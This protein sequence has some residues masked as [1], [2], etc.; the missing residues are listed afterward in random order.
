MNE[1]D[2]SLLTAYLDDELTAGQ[3]REVEAELSRRPELNAILDEL[4]FVRGLV[5]NLPRPTMTNN[6]SEAVMTQLKAGVDPSAKCE[7]AL[8]LVAGN[9][10]GVASCY[11]GGLSLSAMGRG[12]C[13]D[14]G[15]LGRSAVRRRNASAARRI[16]FQP[17]SY[18]KECGLP[19]CLRQRR[20]LNHL[21]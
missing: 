4:R 12:R 16:Y 13:L 14:R 15:S 9:R 2:E 6:L 11:E 3:R 19:N 10:S 17:E 5:A 7:G 1:F 18:G 21:P 8:G 20:G